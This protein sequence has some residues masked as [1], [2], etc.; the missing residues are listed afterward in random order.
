M[1]IA[2][3]KTSSLGDVIHA[4]PV[5]SDIL[6]AH[7]QARIDWV[8]E[9]AFAE[10]PALHPGIARI[11]RVAVRRWRRAPFSRATRS[12]WRSFR[13]GLRAKRY[14]LILDLQGL[15]K[16]ALIARQALGPRAGFDRASAREPLA[17]LF[18]ER[19]YRVEQRQHAIRALRAL[20]SRALGYPIGERPQFGLVAPAAP[21]LALPPAAIVLLHMTAREDK[22]W[23]EVH[24]RELARRLDAQRV[25]VVVP[26]G[27]P[28]EQA[29][30]H[31]IATGL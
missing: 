30:A 14:D 7:P 16:S 8:V 6:A 5:A 28:L 15:I 10:L 18:Y 31:R 3:V 9:E 29:R 13:A 17:A 25:P 2:L 22:Q 23:H 24:W 26:W 20:A 21:G 12:E 11:H 4:L 27:S 19:R 1:D